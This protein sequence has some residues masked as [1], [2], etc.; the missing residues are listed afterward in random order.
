MSLWVE[1]ISALRA[2]IK[3]WQAR[4]I[5][6]LR[7]Y[8]ESHPR[9]VRSATRS[10]SVVDVNDETLRLYEAGEKKELLGPLACGPESIPWAIE[11]IIAVA[12]DRREL[13]MESTA[14]TLRGR[15]L[16]VRTRT[17]IPAE[18]EPDPFV[19]VS[20]IDISRDRSLDPTRA[21]ERVLL[22]AVIDNVPDQVFLKDTEGRFLVVNQA[23]ARW[24]GV[25]DPGQVVG[26]SDLDYFPPEAAEKFRRDDQAI[27]RSG[28]ARANIE[29]QISS[30]S[31]SHGWALTTKAPIRDTS[32]NVIGLVG[33]V[34]DI[35]ERRKVE[36]ALTDAEERY[37][38]IFTD[39][40]VGIF[41][42][43][44]EG[45]LRSV[46]P[47][48]AKMLG[49]DSPEQIIQV[50]N[51]SNAAE[52]LFDDPQ[53]RSALVDALTRAPG[54]H[55]ME[56]R[57]RQR[58]GG[59][60]VV[61][62]TIRLHLPPGAAEPEL[63]G[64]VEDI[65]ER[66]ET[67]QALSRERA[68]LTALMDTIP[69]YIYFKDRE[70]RF[71]L[72]N[73][74]LARGLRAGSPA[75]MRGKTDFDYFAAPHAQKAF[76]D[77]QRILRTGEPLVNAVEEET[78]A[79]RPSTWVSSTKMPLRDEK[80]EIVGTFGISRDMTE[81]RQV[82]EKNLR[83][84]A[85]IESSND[86]IIGVGLDDTVMSWNSGAEKIFGFTAEEM[87]GRPITDFLSSDAGQEPGRM[88]KPSPQ[89][90]VRQ[91]ESSV[92]RKDGATILVSTT[93]SPIQDANGLI[94]G[95]TSISRDVTAERALQTQIMR[96]QRLE[97]LATL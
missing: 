8:L 81:R 72:G 49:Y 92:R 88:E 1:D 56:S 21:E 37:R 96:S 41:H 91:F 47:A 54:W 20:I 33:I 63:E 75:E 12:E 85:M 3:G 66:R 73:K 74:A 79:D 57:R 6:D 80:G 30:A 11:L 46:N 53:S 40:P 29:E 52:A 18:G 84:A 44:L 27:M 50:V 82:E 65:T 19:L 67:E 42:T 48:F 71:I 97:S 5:A 36:K 16:D 22:R 4:G 70:S 83:L 25:G 55:R 31:G 32:G 61:Q 76:D 45:K 35:T 15:K 43:T 59:F 7:P 24:A 39:A 68:F 28:Q 14:L 62:L 23:L 2:S 26:K 90:S 94:I 17:F 93:F 95:I 89:G 87:I 60:A 10:I 51:R 34:R 38:A 13:E 58:D 77:E 64:F 69:D 78:W 9:V 86:A